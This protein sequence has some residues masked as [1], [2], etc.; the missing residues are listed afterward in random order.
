MLDK[1]LDEKE[2]DVI[3]GLKMFRVHKLHMRILLQ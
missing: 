1:S 3:Y 2:L